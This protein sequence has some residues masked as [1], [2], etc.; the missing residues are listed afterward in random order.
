MSFDISFFD[1]KNL[2]LQDQYSIVDSYGLITNKREIKDLT[3]VTYQFHYFSVEIT[4]MSHDEKI[5]GLNAYQHRFER[6]MFI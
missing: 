6:A 2:S 3:F 4:Y 1:F 5:A